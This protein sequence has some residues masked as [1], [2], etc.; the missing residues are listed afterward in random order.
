[1]TVSLGRTLHQPAVRRVASTRRWA[2]A[3]L[4][5][6]A[7][8]A[9]VL[10]APA[11]WLTRAVQDFSQ[12]QVRL[13]QPRGT[14]WNGTA[15]LALAGGSGSTDTVA[16]PGFVTW[17]IRPAWGGLNIGLSASCCTPQPLRIAARAA[18]L[19][20]VHVDLSDHQSSWPTSLLAGLGTPWNTLQLQ[21]QLAV[22]SQGLTLDMTRDRMAVAGQIQVDAMQ[23]SSRLS[24]LKP[25]GSYRVTVQGGSTPTVQ[26]QTLDG[27]LELSGN[28][29][30]VGSRLRF[31]G[32]ATAQ[33]DRIEALSNLLNIIG[34]RNGAQSL[35]KVGSL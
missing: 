20:G 35:I 13:E 23:V 9:V 6:G 14:V 2:F 28:G 18:G 21:G 19:S 12:S 34:R 3:G 24:T 17:Q 30:W 11:R 26:L 32:I 1:M 15:Q 10:W 33:A 25:M 16:L 7:A 29:Q 4:M 5:F 22:R 31:D 27:S 8:I